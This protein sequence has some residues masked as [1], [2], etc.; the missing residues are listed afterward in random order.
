M[1][2]LIY[3]HITHTRFAPTADS[4]LQIVDREGTRTMKPTQIFDRIKAMVYH[5][6]VDQNDGISI[7]A[8]SITGDILHATVEGVTEGSS[9]QADVTARIDNGEFTHCRCSVIDE[10]PPKK[11]KKAIR[12]TSRV[13]WSSDSEES[14]AESGPD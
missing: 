10:P 4:L 11:A 7:K 3:T 8:I 13:I 1:H 6:M 9:Y 5:Q 12:E 14:D 2:C